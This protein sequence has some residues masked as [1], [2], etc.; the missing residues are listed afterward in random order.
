MSLYTGDSYELLIYAC[1]GIYSAL[2]YCFNVKT[3]PAVKEEA[4]KKNVSIRNMKVI[5]HL[6][7]DIKEEINSKMPTEEEETILGME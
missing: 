5:Y 2:I 7:D 3:P 6:V 1:S 4:K